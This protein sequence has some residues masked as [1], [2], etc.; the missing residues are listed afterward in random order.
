MGESYGKYQS[1]MAEMREEP[2]EMFNSVIK[3]TLVNLRKKSGCCTTEQGDLLCI[4]HRT[5]R[6][7]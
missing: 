1:L 5:K 7:L 4:S 6:K 2:H 3:T